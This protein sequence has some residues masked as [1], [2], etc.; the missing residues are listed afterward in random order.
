[1]I[2]SLLISLIAFFTP[3]DP[4]S[5]IS[6]QVNTYISNYKEGVN[7]HLNFWGL[8][9]LYSSNCGIEKDIERA[10]A[11]SDDRF[12]QRIFIDNPCVDQNTEQTLKAKR[13]K[14]YALKTGSNEIAHHYITLFPPNSAEATKFISEYAEKWNLSSA[15]LE[16]FNNTTQADGINFEALFRSENLIYIY[17]LAFSDNVYAYFDSN[18]FNLAFTSLQE[19]F[20]SGIKDPSN[21]NES[22]GYYALIKL[23][24]ELDQYDFINKKFDGL[25]EDYLYPNSQKKVGILSGVDYS[26]SVSGNYYESLYLQRNQLLPLAQH[27]QQYA[28]IDYTLL[29][30]SAALYDLGKFKEAKEILEKLYNDDTTPI[31]KSQL[32]NNLSLSYQKLGEKNKYTS[33]LLQALQEI[34]TNPNIEDQQVLYDVKM[35]LYSN[36]FIYYNS[37]GDPNSAL[38]FIDKAQSIAIENNDKL[39]LATIHAYLGDYYWD[40][41]KDVR[42]ALEEFQKAE[43]LFEDI[44]NYRNKMMLLLNKASMLIKVDSLDAATQV[45]NQIKEFSSE[46]SETPHYIEA[47]IYEAEIASIKG[48]LAALNATLNEIRLYS[49]NN[50]AFEI[51][52]KYH[53]IQAQYLFKSGRTRE[54]FNYINPIV[55]Q[56]IERAKNSVESQTGFWTVE[57]EYLEAFEL[58]IDLLMELDDLRSAIT[59]L[60]RL[61]TINDASLYNNPL[62]KANKLT[63]KELDLDKEL[64]AEIQR[65]RTRYLS[66]NEESKAP[67]KTR[68][69]QLSAQKQELLNKVVDT[70]S[71][72]FLPIWKLQTQIDQNEMLIHFTELNEYLYMSSITQNSIRLTRFELNDRVEGY[73][74][75]AADQL[76]S[77]KTSLNSLYKLYTLLQLDDIP[78]GINQI[79]VFPDNQLY[80]IPLEVLPTSKPNSDKSFGSTN[81]LIER[82]S[83]KYFTSLKEFTFNNRYTRSKSPKDFSAFAISYFD[84][85]KEKSLPSLPYATREVR[86]IQASLAAFDDTEVFIG[87]NA[88]E[89]AFQQELSKSKII[90]IASHSEVSEQDPLFSTIY[91]KSNNSNSTTSEG[92]ALYAYELF[93]VTLN[94]DLIMLNSCSSGS[95]NYMQ[96]TGIMGISRSLRYAGAKSLA[97]N[98]WVVNDKIASE[99][100]TNFYS[101][102]NRGY[103]KS[104][105]M[106]LAKIDQLKTGNADPHFWGAYTLI[107]NPAPVIRKPKNSQL[108]YP[109]LLIASLLIGY[110]VRRKSGYKTV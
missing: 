78:K 108:V 56:I 11:Q 87:N 43:N 76:A 17:N 26:L 104:T 96:G 94:N 70:N 74:K 41:F 21:I 49:L 42:K 107:G 54:A 62:L 77:G 27:Y 40:T 15:P 102:L 69:D 90:H 57:P 45:V 71:D 28:R 6:D 37:I 23:A 50:L 48:N 9:E 103:S 109:V 33:F 51:L 92:N 106:R 97:L 53:T 82:Y 110:S 4:Y 32:Y 36:L 13:L 52:V 7:P 25:V 39:S 88:T 1:M 95:G 55:D 20:A 68:I 105:S 91:L 67:I 59:Y 2:L 29:R 12:I 86:N 3:I 66:A 89:A 44:D 19:R 63:E 83:F 24:Y 60:D 14:D 18:T 64:T 38:P 5:S 99:F 85:F 16:F 8:N 79:A 58:I 46:N 101:Y 31:P 34:D 22:I 61:K 65:L 84:D 100:A 93:D 72:Q 35:G 80:R 30:Q 10:I 73:F 47:L 81:Y 98:M 75:D